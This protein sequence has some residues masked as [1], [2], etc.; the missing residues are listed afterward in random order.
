MDIP[1]YLTNI[2]DIT[3]NIKP[4]LIP[5]LYERDLV[6]QPPFIINWNREKFIELLEM[7]NEITRKIA[8]NT[9]GVILLELPSIGREGYRVLEKNNSNQQDGGAW[10]HFSKKGLNKMG[11]NVAFEFCKLN[12]S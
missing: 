1:E 7:N 8:K 5:W 6:S 9:E 4:I 12:E 2:S 3:K 10:I 11:E